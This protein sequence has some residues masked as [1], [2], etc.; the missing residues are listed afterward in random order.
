[1]Q[2]AVAGAVAAANTRAVSR[3]AK[4]QR[5]LLLP[6]DFTMGGGEV[7]ATMKLRRR[8]IA[9]KYAAEVEVWQPWHACAK[10]VCAYGCALRWWEFAR[11]LPDVLSPAWRTVVSFRDR[12]HAVRNAVTP[13]FVCRLCALLFFCLRQFMPGR[14]AL[15]LLEPAWQQRISVCLPV[16][17]WDGAFLVCSQWRCR[18]H[19]VYIGFCVLSRFRKHTSLRKPACFTSTLPFP[20]VQGFAQGGTWRLRGKAGVESRLACG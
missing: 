1:V 6:V 20:P 12:V 2:A 7:T 11:C 16:F 19:R 17:S 13:T 3:A 4:L 15:M 9:S 5:V 14:R 8:V 10:R 18:V